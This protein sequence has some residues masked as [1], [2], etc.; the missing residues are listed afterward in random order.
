MASS[1]SS[2]TTA[3]QP[4][5]NRLNEY[6]TWKVTEDTVTLDNAIK[7]AAS[8]GDPIYFRF[9][10]YT[11]S[12]P[13]YKPD[14]TSDGRILHHGFFYPADPAS[15]MNSGQWVQGSAQLLSY[16]SHFV[17]GYGE[18]W[19]HAKPWYIPSVVVRKVQ[20]HEFSDDF[21]ATANASCFCMLDRTKTQNSGSYYAAF[22]PDIRAV[23][24]DSGI[25]N[26]RL[27]IYHEDQV[28]NPHWANTASRP[29]TALTIEGIDAS[30]IC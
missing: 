19:D 13:Y 25:F 7:Y 5:L 24:G 30:S 16:H 22:C 18:V 2:C 15:D 1:S 8:T 29:G 3:I 28:V 23:S 17:P 9:I 20:S 14:S 4:A 10:N 27:T 11:N 26:P 12:N 6:S 21:P